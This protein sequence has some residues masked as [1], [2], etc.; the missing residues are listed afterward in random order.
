M[1]SLLGV[2]QR[3][4]KA[5]DAS[6]VLEPLSEPRRDAERRPRGAG[7]LLQVRGLECVRRERVLFTDLSFSV[8]P[9]A[10]VQ[11]VGA[12]GSGKTSLLRL[13]CGLT[14]PERG[15]ILWRGESI[16]EA[17]GRFQADLAFV[18]HAPG[19]KGELSPYENLRLFC[20]LHGARA[21][22]D[23]DAALAEAGLASA[24]DLPLHK[25]SAGQ[26]RRAALARLLITTARLWILD[27]PLTSLDTAGVHFVE[28]TV[29]RH[30]AGGG[31]VVM[32]THQPFKV[33]DGNV[34]RVRLG[35]V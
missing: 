12:N 11:V 31:A 28:T 22:A 27:E 1:S 20:R 2:A 8:E 30:L 24:A 26:Q 14:R 6:V 18:G 32:S 9:R 13:L 33:T 35:D 23:P 34:M 21:G 7:T 19:V 10:M 15:E 4:A 29:N 16:D 3:R 17:G 5:A 25:L